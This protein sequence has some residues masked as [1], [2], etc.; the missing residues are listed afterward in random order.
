MLFRHDKALIHI[1]NFMNNSKS[2]GTGFKSNH[3]HLLTNK[4]SIGKLLDQRTVC[5]TYKTAVIKSTSQGC[6]EGKI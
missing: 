1:N 2:T 5:L 6:C 4:V 3:Y